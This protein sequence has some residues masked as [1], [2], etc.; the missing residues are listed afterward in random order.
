MEVFIPVEIFVIVVG[1]PLLALEIALEILV[2]LLAALVER[3]ALLSA[4]KRLERSLDSRKYGDLAACL[5][6]SRIGRG[7]PSGDGLQGKP[8]WFWA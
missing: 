6:G 3:L 5:V 7:A 4:E 1:I 2:E 8:L